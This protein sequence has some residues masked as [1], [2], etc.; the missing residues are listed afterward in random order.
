M[1]Q[2]QKD[3][4]GKK[5]GKKIIVGYD[6]GRERAQISYCGLEE[7]EPET[8]SAVAGTEQYN[9]PAVLC[10]RSGVSQWYYGKEALKFAEE[11]EG[12]V[13]EHLL[14]LAERG[15]DVLVEGEVFDPVALLTL[16][17]KRSLSLLSMRV[18]LNQ[19]EAFMFTV[20]EL[21]PRIVD[22]L[23][24]VAVGLQLKAKHIA[25]QNYSESFY[26]YTLH[27]EREIWK[28]DVVVFE[29]D[30]TLKVLCLECNRRTRPQVVFIQQWNFPKIERRVWK[31]E[32]GERQ[33]QMDELDALFLH[34]AGEVLTGRLVSTVFLLGDGFK[35]NWMKESLKFLCRNRRVFQG[36][37]LYSKGAC[38]GMRERLS[39]GREWQEYVYLGDEKLKSNI[40]LRALRQGEDSYFA[41]LDAGTNWY[42]ASSEFEII[43]EDGNTVEFVITPLTGGNVTNR[44]VSLEGLPERPGRTTRLNVQVEMASVSQVI[45]T[46]SDEGFGELF[47]SSGKAW[48]RTITV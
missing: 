7:S 35:E 26:A 9:I 1:L 18:P 27:Q 47:K 24:K 25:F 29:Y 44:T 14:T 30:H 5:N 20:E 6:L 37:N 16:F 8:I 3:F 39:P 45:I 13:V 43:L 10:K 48:T 21:T 36:N 41:V 31:E 46:V 17:I 23:G 40:G 4:I 12:I 32:E 2:N 15:E 28:N 19:I 11:E 42:E 34:L 38:Y 22:V 33:Q